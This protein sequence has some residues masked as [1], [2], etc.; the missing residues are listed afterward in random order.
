[1]TPTDKLLWFRFSLR[2]LFVLVTVAACW[3]GY[4]VNWIRL[5]RAVVADLPRWQALEGIPNTSMRQPDAPGL[6]WM[7]GEPGYAA[8]SLLVPVDTVDEALDESWP[9][10]KVAAELQRVE[11]LFPEAMVGAAPIEEFTIEDQLDKASRLR[12]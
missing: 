2:T 1:M 11:R 6:L 3:L 10:R 4:E 12:R 9:P 5:R 7:F 8:V